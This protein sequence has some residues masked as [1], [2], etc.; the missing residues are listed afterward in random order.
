[1]TDA[2]AQAKQPEI[3]LVAGPE[4]MAAFEHNLGYKPETIIPSS[5][6]DKPGE[7][8]PFAFGVEGF[9]S[10]LV[11]GRIFD[12]NSGEP[13]PEGSELNITFRGPRG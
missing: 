8:G 4:G 13:A 5:L 2:T 7:L 9:N 6:D 1:M 3:K 12:R 11:V 10:T